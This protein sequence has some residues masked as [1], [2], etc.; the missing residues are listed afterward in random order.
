VAAG[1]GA[2]SFLLGQNHLGELGYEAFIHE[3]R[4]RAVSE[5]GGLGHRVRWNVREMVIPWELGDA[6]IVVS[7]LFNVLP[8]TARLRRRPRT[9]ALDFAFATVLDR[10]GGA[11][12]RLLLASLRS[13][14]AIVS[15]SESQRERLLERT[16]LPPGRV[17]TV[18][19]G[20]D[21][22]FLRPSADGADD[23][24]VLAVG[25]DLARDYGT[26]AQ[27]AARVDA[28]FVVVTEE[29]NLRGIELPPNVEVRRGF[30]YGALRDLYAR[31]RCVVLPLRRLDY[32]YGTE[33]G[34]LTAL[35][36]A[37]AM[38]KP[39]VSSDRPIT[40][41]YV[42][43]N[44][45]ALVVPPEDADALAA[46]LTRLLADDVLAAS[47]G[48]AARR[49]IDEHHTMRQFARGLADVFDEIL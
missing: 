38:G 21:H 12:R 18:L 17:R 48:A 13:A 19:L 32:P 4:I 44:E 22:E 16:G 26:L 41:E 43:A 49:R 11:G 34:G 3:P 27:A 23:G 10:R 35:M 45:S 9:V 6:D 8:L 36:E 42:R 14:S 24:Y 15:L 39:V 20:I 2:D 40:H 46:A 1:S 31:A 30:T 33:S 7:A 25:K 28:R 47:L 37:M 29:R 5:R